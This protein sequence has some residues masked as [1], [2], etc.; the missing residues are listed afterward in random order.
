MI[1]AAA[2]LFPRLRPSVTSVSGSHDVPPAHGGCDLRLRNQGHDLQLP[3]Q[4]GRLES[5]VIVDVPAV[6]E[7]LAEAHDGR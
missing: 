1:T 5:V 3:Y 2:P 6:G 7:P 4:C